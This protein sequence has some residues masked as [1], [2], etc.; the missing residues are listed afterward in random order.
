MKITV[1]YDKDTQLFALT[2]NEA[3]YFLTVD[4]VK[5]KLLDEFDRELLY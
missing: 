5:N 2:L 1:K 3:T 4:E